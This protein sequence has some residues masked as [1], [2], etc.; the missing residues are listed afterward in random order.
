MRA[1]HNNHWNLNMEKA[2]LFPIHVP[3]IITCQ[4]TST[5]LRHQTAIIENVTLP[6]YSSW[7]N[8]WKTSHNCALQCCHSLKHKATLPPKENYNHCSGKGIKKEKKERYLN[9]ATN[10]TN[11]YNLSIE[12][13]LQHTIKDLYGC[14]LYKNRVSAQGFTWVQG[15]GKKMVLMSVKKK[16]KKRESSSLTKHTEPYSWN[17]HTDFGSTENGFSGISSI[18][19]I[20]KM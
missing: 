19:F 5:D 2:A 20:Y 11:K 16:E 18:F 4:F 9:S 17:G 15:G 7:A 8:H 10:N 1:Q 3:E 12:E 6:T 13:T 14:N